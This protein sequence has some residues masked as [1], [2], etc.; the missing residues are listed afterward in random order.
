MIH[1]AFRQNPRAL[2]GSLG[3]ALVLATPTFALAGG[4][5]W[6][7][8]F[9]KAKKQA[10]TEKKDLLLD[11]TGS[12][13]CGWCIRLNKEV[14]DQEAFKKASPKHF[15]LVE[16]DFPRGK[17]LAPKVK[18]Q[19][20]KLQKEFAVQGFPTIFLT[21]NLG[22]P[23]AQTGY[24]PG[25][26][27]A[28]L[29]HLEELRQ[30]RVTRD[31]H[32]G[33]AMKAEGIEQAKHL[34]AGLAALPAAMLFPAYGAVVDQIIKLDKDNKA[35]LKEQY[36]LAKKDAALLSKVAEIEQAL[37]KA[38]QGGDEEA[39]NKVLGRLDEI[40][41]ETGGKGAAAQKVFLIQAQLAFGRD[42]QPAK[43]VELLEKMVAAA[44]DTD[45]AKHMKENVIPQIKQQI[46]G[47][48]N[49]VDVDDDEAEE[50]EGE[51]KA[52]EPEDEDGDE[53]KKAKKQAKKKAAKQGAGK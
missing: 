28:Y 26:P 8:D 5:G 6:T 38:A 13:W 41:K 29:K 1:R 35:G 52:E 31:E 23:Y 30:K 14:F 37:G 21:D 53:N 3:L 46:A 9:E 51:D 10:T 17:E 45:E 18:A 36:E 19:N 40:I 39:M 33:K 50:P 25:G 27:E 42:N 11:F 44:P 48:E 12:D 34:S 2:A 20:E 47:L 24:Q 49:P 43:A 7:D 4:E 22:R 32:F 15:V 16:L